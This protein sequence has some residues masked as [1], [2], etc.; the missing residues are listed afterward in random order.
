MGFVRSALTHIKLPGS[1]KNFDIDD[2]SWNNKW[3]HAFDLGE[4]LHNNHHKYPG[5]YNE[6]CM[7]GEFDFAGYLVEKLFVVK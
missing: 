6:A 7:P 2:D 3:L 5:R 4:G 1:Y